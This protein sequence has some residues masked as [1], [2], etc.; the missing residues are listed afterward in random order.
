MGRPIIMGVDGEAREI[1]KASQSGL[2]IDPDNV[3]QLVEALIRLADN[4]ELTKE[5]SEAGRPFVSQ[6]YTRDVLAEELLK[7]LRSV[8]ING[9]AE[10]IES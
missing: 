8:A 6:Y 3:D 10:A 1:V 7:I 2:D 5:L 4:P 9:S